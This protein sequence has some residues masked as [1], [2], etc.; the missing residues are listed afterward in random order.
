MD[1]RSDRTCKRRAIS[2]SQFLRP[3]TLY[4]GWPYGTVGLAIEGGDLFAQAALT[5]GVVGPGAR[6]GQVQEAVHK[7]TGSDEPRAGTRG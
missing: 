6:A 3:M 7:I 5:L 1:T 2:R 4:A